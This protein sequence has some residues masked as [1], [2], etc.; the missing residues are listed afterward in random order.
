MALDLSDS[1][2]KWENHF[3]SMAQGKI[4]LDDIYIIP[5]K[6][7]GLGST[8]RGKAMY[9]IQIGKQS[10]TPRLTTSNKVTTPINRGYAMAQARIYKTKRKIQ[11]RRRSK[12]RRRRS[13]VIKAKKSTVRRR[14]TSAPSRRKTS[15][16]TRRK[17][18][19]TVRNSNTKRRKSRKRDIFG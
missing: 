14:K 18:S 11:Q 12:S 7:R 16:S 2:Q 10:T 8:P 3:K 5:Q 4:P 9:K 1:V 19:R 13:K 6:G 15:K 17:T